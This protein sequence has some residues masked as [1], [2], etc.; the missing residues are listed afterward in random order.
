MPARSP[1]KAKR[2]YNKPEAFEK[3][4]EEG[5]KEVAA[6]YE[7]HSQTLQAMGNRAYD[8]CFMSKGEQALVLRALKHFIHD[9]HQMI[10][11]AHAKYAQRNRAVFEDHRQHH[12]KQVAAA[13]ALIERLQRGGIKSI[14]VTFD[15]E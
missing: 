3:G 1:R 15:K 7:K 4:V 5:F 10:S 12:L 14:P 11:Q 2:T 9:Q 8:E 13:D 6:A